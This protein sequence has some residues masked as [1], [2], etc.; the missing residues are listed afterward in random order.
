MPDPDP[1]RIQIESFSG[2]VHRF[3]Y[4][5]MRKNAWMIITR[6]VRPKMIRLMMFNVLL[7]SGPIEVASPNKS[8]LITP[9]F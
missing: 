3:I 9:S 6:I 5:L 7:L 2:V 8:P 1:D 4:F